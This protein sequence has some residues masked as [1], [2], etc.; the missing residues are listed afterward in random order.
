MVARRGDAILEITLTIPDA[1]PLIRELAAEPGLLIG[2]GTV[3]DRAD[4]GGLPGCRGAIPG[5]A[6]DRSRG[7]PGARDG[8][9]L[10]PCRA[11]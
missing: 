4:G 3:P 8:R 11:P 6:L 5:D 1:L 7:D 10:L 9:R 2:A